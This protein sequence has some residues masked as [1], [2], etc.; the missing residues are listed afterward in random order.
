[1]MFSIGSTDE[2]VLTASKDLTDEPVL[3]RC[4]KLPQH[5]DSGAPCFQPSTP[6][7]LYRL[8]YFESLGTVCEEI[9]R[10]F[11]QEDLKVV[12]DMESLLL[13]SANGMNPSIPQVI[14]AMYT[15]ELD[16]DRLATHLKM[17][18]DVIQ[19]YNAYSGFV[20]KKVQ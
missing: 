8:N 4:R 14:T 7:G 11:D 19:Q 20:I 16:E 3:P 9:R 10:W 17:L 2:A 1:M 6:R 5:F 18:P 12:A 13:D 15:R